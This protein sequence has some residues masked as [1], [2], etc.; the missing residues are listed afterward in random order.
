MLCGALIFMTFNSPIQF[1]D[2][3]DGALRMIA[4]LAWPGFILGGMALR[5]ALD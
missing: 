4:T 1:A 2:G 3:L 5:R